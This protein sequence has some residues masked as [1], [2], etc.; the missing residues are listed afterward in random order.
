LI[1]APL[2]LFL[3]AWLAERLQQR[4]DD[5]NLRVVVIAWIL[6]MPLMV[7]GP[8]FG[9]AELAVVAGGLAGMFSLMAAPTQN[10][11]LQSV[12]PN[13]MRGQ[14][15]ALYL[16]TYVLAAQGIGPSFIAAITEFVVR[17]EAGL[18]YAL[19]GSAAVMMPLAILTIWL[20][21]H[22]YGREIARLKMSETT[23]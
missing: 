20:G 5:A 6:A 3:G 2:G 1:A 10:A 8:L 11:A 21:M 13:E 19:A 16:L 18:R 17:D 14:I 7:A 4:H 9:S 15:T 23:G 22:P 12:T